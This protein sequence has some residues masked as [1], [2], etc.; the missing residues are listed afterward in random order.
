MRMMLRAQLSTPKSSE[1][2][3]S[4]KLKE[5]MQKTMELLKPEAA[6]FTAEGGA[7]TMFLFFDMQDS[8]MMPTML[9]PLFG[10]LHAEITLT[11]A[12]NPNDL[13]KGLSNIGL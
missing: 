13:M 9:E 4:G 11:P 7:R 1:A 12:M 2:L 10:E 5:V 3:R 6:Y 8:A